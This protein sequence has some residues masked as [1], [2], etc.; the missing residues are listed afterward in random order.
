MHKVLFLIYY[1][2]ITVLHHNN[3]RFASPWG[4]ERSG[5]Q[6]GVVLFCFV[7]L[8]DGLKEMFAFFRVGVEVD[9]I[10]LQA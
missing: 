9:R 1:L 2:L 8:R 3:G 7:I 6:E 5:L 10:V 4:L